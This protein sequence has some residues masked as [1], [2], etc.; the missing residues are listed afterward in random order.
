MAMCRRLNHPTNSHKLKWI[1]GEGATTCNLANS[2]PI[3]TWYT[4]GIMGKIA[5]VRRS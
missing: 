3:R 5:G 2:A 4:R 1:G